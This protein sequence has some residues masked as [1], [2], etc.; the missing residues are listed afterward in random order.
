MWVKRSFINQ[1]QQDPEWVREFVKFLN[2]NGNKEK[3]L[4]M[5][6]IFIDAYLENIREGM[7][8]EEALQKAKSVALCFLVLQQ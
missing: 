3:F 1:K 4:V 6:K 2:T 7:N 8:P 5:K